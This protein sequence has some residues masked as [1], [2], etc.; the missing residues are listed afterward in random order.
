MSWAP[1]ALVTCHAGYGEAGMESSLGLG[2]RPDR[3]PWATGSTHHSCVSHRSSSSAVSGPCNLKDQV[4][5]SGKLFFPLI[6][7][8]TICFAPF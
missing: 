1:I 5:S 2:G 7:A 8:L 3:L 6:I 4:F